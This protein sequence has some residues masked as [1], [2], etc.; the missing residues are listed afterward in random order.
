MPGRFWFPRG[1]LTFAEP[2][3]LIPA[4][5]SVRLDSFDAA[6]GRAELTACAA[7]FAWALPH[8]IA[9]VVTET[10]SYVRAVLTPEP[11]RGLMPFR[12]QGHVVVWCAVVDANGLEVREK[13]S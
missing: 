3:R 7:R 2:L 12:L 4:G 5:L 1:V 9:D 13:K 8:G 11:L 6:T 10:A